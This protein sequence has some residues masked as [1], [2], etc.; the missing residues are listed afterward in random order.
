MSA[1]VQTFG[2][3]GLVAVTLWLA[4]LGLVVIVAIAALSEALRHGRE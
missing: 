2:A 4:M 1:I 3:A